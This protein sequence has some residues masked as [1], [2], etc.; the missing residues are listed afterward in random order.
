MKTLVVF[1][2]VN[3]KTFV[4]L[5]TVFR[6]LKK[7]GNDILFLTLAY[8]RGVIKWRKQS[9]FRTELMRMS[10]VYY[11]P[12]ITNHTSCVWLENYQAGRPVG[13]FAFEWGK[14]YFLLRVIIK[15]IIVSKGYGAD[16]KQMSPYTLR[17]S[18]S[19][20]AI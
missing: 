19:G 2:F 14:I 1:Y 10:G 18:F 9:Y 16:S 11:D 3:N 15:I 8:N 7:N 20:I 5:S 13:Y 12:S 17:G 4:S 6:E